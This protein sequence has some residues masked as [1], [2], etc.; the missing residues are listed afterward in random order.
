MKPT[1]VGTGFTKPRYQGKR[2]GGAPD[3]AG[4]KFCAAYGQ[5][6]EC[7]TYLKRHFFEIPEKN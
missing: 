3:F 2:N 5:S 7:S 1:H 6:V 4:A